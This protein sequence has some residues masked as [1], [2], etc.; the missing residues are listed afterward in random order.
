MTIF[1]IAVLVVAFGA[2]VAVGVHSAA[3]VVAKIATLHTDIAAIKQ[4]LGI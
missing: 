2:G 4:K 3:T 1:V